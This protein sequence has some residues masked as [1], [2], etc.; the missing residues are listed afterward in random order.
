VGGIDAEAAVAYLAAGAIAVGVGSPLL[1]DAVTG[2]DLAGLAARAR[3]F[4]EAV[5]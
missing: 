5:A 3:R 1:G 4:L 2:G